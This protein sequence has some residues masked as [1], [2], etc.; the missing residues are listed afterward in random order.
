[1]KFE[2]LGIKLELV[3]MKFWS[4][5]WNLRFQNENWDINWN[6]RSEWNFGSQKWNSRYSEW[7]LRFQNEIW[8]IKMK[9]ER[10]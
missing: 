8:D 6:L 4:Q 10:V 2:I 1:M 5:E 9:S 3:K 7:N